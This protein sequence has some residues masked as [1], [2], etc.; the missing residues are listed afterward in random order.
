V[1]SLNHTFTAL[2]IPRD[3]VKAGKT[4]T[5]LRLGDPVVLQSRAR[6]LVQDARGRFWLQNADG[7]RITPSGQYDFV[8]LPDGSIRV[9]RTNTNPEFSTHLGLSGGK[10][11]SFA[12][13]IRFAN[14]N[15]AT[16]GS[17]RSWTNNSGHYQPPASLA[18]NAGLPINLFTPF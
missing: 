1:D 10:E 6:T 13:S 14:S 3:S 16:R 2:G 4:L 15:T 11:V 17:I 5:N 8:K 9:V 12:G 7:K 18:S